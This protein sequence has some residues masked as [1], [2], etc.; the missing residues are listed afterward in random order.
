MHFKKSLAGKSTLGSGWH[1]W[2][3]ERNCG[4]PSPHSSPAPS[5]PASLCSSHARTHCPNTCPLT[6]YKNVVDTTSQQVLVECKHNIA[7]NRKHLPLMHAAGRGTVESDI[8]TGPGMKLCPQAGLRKKDS[9]PST[10]AATHEGHQWHSTLILN[11]AHIPVSFPTCASPTSH[12]PSATLTH[13]T[14]HSVIH[15]HKRLTYGSQDHLPK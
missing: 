4:S 2:A 13:I 10:A 5:L 15:K 8:R 9:A 11:P 12:F 6:R 1:T 14:P 7:L 3:A